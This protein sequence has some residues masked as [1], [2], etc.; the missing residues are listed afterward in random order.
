M[1]IN[2][3]DILTDMDKRRLKYLA[4]TLQQDMELQA[5]YTSPPL[6]PRPPILPPRI[7][8]LLEQRELEIEQCN[9]LLLLLLAYLE[10]SLPLDVMRA[11]LETAKLT[12]IG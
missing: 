8:S 4:H 10:Y 3:H 6:P 1:C 11:T 5:K 12:N 7:E 2:E 9:M